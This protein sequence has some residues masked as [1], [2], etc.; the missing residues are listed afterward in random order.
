MNFEIRFIVLSFIVVIAVLILADSLASAAL[1]VSLVASFLVLYFHFNK[2]HC[3]LAA[4]SG[5]EEDKEEGLTTGREGASE[6]PTNNSA[7]S[8]ADIREREENPYTHMYGAAQSKYDLFR[9]GMTGYPTPLPGTVFAEKDVLK[10]T[11][12]PSDN[13]YGVDSLNVYMAQR[14]FRDKKMYEGIVDKNMDY[15]KHHF[16]DEL[17]E[18]ESRPW[19][20]RAEY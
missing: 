12:G 17:S 6:M 18:A 13:V 4:A 9:Y 20:G 15:Y 11:G 8:L 2:L 1:T 14:R 16:G 10:V 5:V 19:W 7:K 3:Q